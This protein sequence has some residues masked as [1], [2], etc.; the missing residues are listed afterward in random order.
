MSGNSRNLFSSF[1]RAVTGFAGTIAVAREMNEL[2][3]TPDHTFR[4]RGTTR[5]AAIRKVMSRL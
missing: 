2:F 4:A 5:D 1:S 3:N